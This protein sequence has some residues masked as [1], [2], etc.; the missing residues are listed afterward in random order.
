MFKQTSAAVA[1]G[2]TVLGIAFM[3]TTASAAGHDESFKYNYQDPVLTRSYCGR[4]WTR[5]STSSGRAQ[6]DYAGEGAPDDN[7]HDIGSFETYFVAQDGSGDSWRL[8]GQR[9]MRITPVQLDA[10]T[11]QVTTQVSGRF[12]K[13]TSASGE[14][15]WADRGTYR[16]FVTFVDGEYDSDDM[17]TAG[18]QRWI[19]FYELDGLGCQMVADAVAAG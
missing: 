15:I 6:I 3:P 18:K 9:N 8:D 17:W 11:W 7:I 1:A 4:D 16:E 14:L 10:N 12:W 5:T 2:L 19:N 13:V